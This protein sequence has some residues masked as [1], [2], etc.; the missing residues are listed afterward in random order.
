MIEVVI[1]IRIKI[2]TAIT[3]RTAT[4]PASKIEIVI[5]VATIIGPAEKL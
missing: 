5:V 3:I 2:V 1:I 4:G